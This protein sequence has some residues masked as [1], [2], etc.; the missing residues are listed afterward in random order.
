MLAPNCFQMISADAT[1]FAVTDADGRVDL[2]FRVPFDPA[3]RGVAI[4]AQAAVLD[5]GPV[6]GMSLTGAL[7]IVIGD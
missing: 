3:L 1:L 5:G 4:L 7:Q 2:P 6:F